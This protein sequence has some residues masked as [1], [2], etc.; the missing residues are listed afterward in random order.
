MLVYPLVCPSF[1]LLEACAF[2]STFP[3]RTERQPLK[4]DGPS[5][6]SGPSGAPVDPSRQHYSL[7]SAPSGFALS[8]W[9]NENADTVT[10]LPSS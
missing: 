7:D 5:G 4:A 10:S 1:R 3:L 9:I 6:P 2:L 8:G